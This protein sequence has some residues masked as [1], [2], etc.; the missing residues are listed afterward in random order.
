M[1]ATERLS[2]FFE[3]RRAQIR[4]LQQKEELHA[5]AE[6]LFAMAG[7]LVDSQE[8]ERRR[9]AREIH[10]DFT[11]RLALV[12][13]KIG[14]LAGRDRTTT[15]REL[16]AGLEDVRKT[17]AAVANDLRDLSHQLHPAMLEILGLV[18]ALR[19]QCEDIQRARGIETQ[20]DSSVS[21]SDAS[22][23]AAM[24]LYRVLQESLMN[25]AKHSGSTSA[26][27]SLGP[28][29]GRARNAGAGR[30]SRHRA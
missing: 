7:R 24:C 6:R 12:S 13:M 15:S 14:N 17:T 16:D 2:R 30:R 26:R 27:V 10:D 18:G 11:Q 25:I 5:S 8:E 21:D 9:I 3:R 1:A 22:P 29:S 4:F 23:Q 19:A 28:Q 20:F